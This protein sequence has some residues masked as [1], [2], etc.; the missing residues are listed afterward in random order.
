MSGDPG[1]P[2]DIRQYDNDPRSP[3]YDSRAEEALEDELWERM[4]AK[5]AESMED[6]N[7]YDCWTED[8][9][10][11]AAGHIHLTELCS[12]IKMKK[13][14]SQE[15][16]NK[17]ASY[18]ISMFMDYVE[19]SVDKQIDTIRDELEKTMEAENEPDYESMAESRHREGGQ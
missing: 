9:D 2:D 12:R 19:R 3:F 17:V 15:E 18:T 8:I 11:D 5:I 10:Y 4:P 16:L 14:V 6:D 13:P 1:Y 7:Y